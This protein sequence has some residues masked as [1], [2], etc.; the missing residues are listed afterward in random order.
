MG[1]DAA[2]MAGGMQAWA[3]RGLPVVRDDGSPGEVI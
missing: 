1:F 2:N 3:E